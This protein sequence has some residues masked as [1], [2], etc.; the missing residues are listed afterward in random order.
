MSETEFLENYFEEELVGKFVQVK[1]KDFKGLPKVEIDMVNRLAVDIA[2]K[3]EPFLILF[4]NNNKRVEVPI[5]D[6]RTHIKLL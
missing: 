5:D 2:T 6:L 3:P 4:L 1:Y